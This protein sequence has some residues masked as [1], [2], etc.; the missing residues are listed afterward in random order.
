MLQPVKVHAQGNVPLVRTP[1]RVLQIVQYVSP[2]DLRDTPGLEPAECVRPASSRHSLMLHLATHARLAI[3]RC[4]RARPSAFHSHHRATSRVM[5]SNCHAALAVLHP[6]LASWNVRLARPVGISR[7]EPQPAALRVRVASTAQTRLAVAWQPKATARR[8]RLETTSTR[9]PR[10][11][12]RARS[13]SSRVTRIS[14]S[15]RR[16]RPVHSKA[17]QGKCTARTVPRASTRQEAEPASA[18]RARRQGTAAAGRSIAQL[19][20]RAS[21]RIQW[22]AR[23]ARLACWVASVRRMQQSAGNALWEAIAAPWVL[24][25]V[26]TAQLASSRRQPARVHVKN[27]L[28]C[29]FKSRRQSRRANRAPPGSTRELAA[30][31]SA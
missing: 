26:R 18:S 1:W 30:R 9:T 25:F 29:T 21:T 7:M 11:A 15:A 19:V 2:E 24:Q 16:A 5:E 27:A 8:A 14:S 13:A 17:T 22:G 4:W 3:T 31:H 10:F 6:H 23:R 12:R 20:R 28:R